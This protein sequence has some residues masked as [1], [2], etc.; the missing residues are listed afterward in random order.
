[1]NHLIADQE[2]ELHL[3]GI[4]ES[5][6]IRDRTGK[7]MG[8]YMPVV[9]PEELANYEKARELFDAEELA[10]VEREEGSQG[11][12]LVEFWESIRGGKSSR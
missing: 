1:M 3:R 5:V 11:R 12:P 10:R 2:L 6:E 7:V 8:Y 4:L 9:S